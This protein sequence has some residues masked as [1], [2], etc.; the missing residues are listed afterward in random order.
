LQNSLVQVRVGKGF[1]LS[2]MLDHACSIVRAV[3]VDIT[4]GVP[5]MAFWCSKRN[6]VKYRGKE[7]FGNFRPRQRRRKSGNKPV[8]AKETFPVKGLEM[9]GLGWAKEDSFGVLFEAL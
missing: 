5:R 9:M 7:G 2:V 4:K 6:L 8:G 3:D 1:R